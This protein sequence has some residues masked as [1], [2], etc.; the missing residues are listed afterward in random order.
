M[1]KWSLIEII[2]LGIGFGVGFVIWKSIFTALVVVLAIKLLIL[3][4]K[5][6]YEFLKAIYPNRT[7]SK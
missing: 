4:P 5:I 7:A 1:R 3:T 6:L 2:T